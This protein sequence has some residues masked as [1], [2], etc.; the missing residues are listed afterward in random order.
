MR[1]A[2]GDAAERFSERVLDGVVR[3]LLDQALEVPNEPGE[4][5]GGMAR[6]LADAAAARE[7]LVERT[8][9]VDRLDR[10]AVELPPK[11]LAGGRQQ[12]A[13]HRAEDLS[14]GLRV[15]AITARRRLAD[16]R[17]A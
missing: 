16:S 10:V 4:E 6:R 15:Y 5:D 8:R 14:V 7:D 9:G 1:E 12:L 2:C 11:G 17:W 13:D 3:E